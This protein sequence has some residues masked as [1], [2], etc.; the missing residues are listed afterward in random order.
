MS[1]LV[2]AIESAQPAQ[3]TT[4]ADQAAASNTQLLTESLQKIAA[5]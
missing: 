1:V 4:A 3:P 2:T 5:A